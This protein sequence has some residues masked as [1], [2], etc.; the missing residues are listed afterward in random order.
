MSRATTSGRPKAPSRPRRASGGHGASH[1]QPPRKPR[2]QTPR[3][4]DRHKQSGTP[5]PVGFHPLAQGADRRSYVIPIGA[6]GVAGTL[7]L[8]ATSTAEM[9]AALIALLHWRV[10]AI[11]RG[12][13]SDAAARNLGATGPF[14]HRVAIRYEYEGKVHWYLPDYVAR[15]RD[16]QPIV[17]EAGIGAKKGEPLQLAKLEAARAWAEAQ[18]GELWVIAADLVLGRWVRGALGLYLSRLDYSR[19][20]RPAR[21]ITRAWEAERISIGALCTRFAEG[22]EARGGRRRRP[23]GGG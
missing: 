10:F 17:I 7:G 15:T 14:G 6:K 8:F 19:R 4:R 21:V 2:N 5:G 12:D 18:G 20:P 3:P 11:G 23:Q 22:H 13:I 9:I 1:P 16:G